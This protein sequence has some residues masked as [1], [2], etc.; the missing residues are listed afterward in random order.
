MA[1][2]LLLTLPTRQVKFVQFI[3]SP[4]LLQWANFVMNGRLQM[5]KMY[6]AKFQELWKCKVKVV[7]LV[8]FTELYK[9]VHYL[10]LLP[11]LRDFY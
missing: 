5:L 6:L 2:K 3:R 4:H 7:L 8:P 9:P 10:Q 1:M 11:A